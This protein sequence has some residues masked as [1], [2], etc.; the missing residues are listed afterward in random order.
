[1][2]GDALETSTGY[3]PC[4]E[5]G[6]RKPD[7][8]CIL[9]AHSKYIH[10]RWRHHFCVDCFPMT[11]SDDKPGPLGDMYLLMD[12]NDRCRSR[13]NVVPVVVNDTLP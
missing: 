12:C 9:N 10:C 4:Y 6:K 5:C 7:G 13:A 11:E 8:R 1:M 2:P 3:S